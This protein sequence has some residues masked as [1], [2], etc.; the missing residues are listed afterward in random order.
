MAAW[1]KTG[2]AWPRYGFIQTQTLDIRFE[3]LR[4]EICDLGSGKCAL[5][6]TKSHQWKARSQKQSCFL[7]F[8]E[9]WGDKGGGVN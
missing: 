3:D 9:E 2:D 4:R 1:A 7:F 8:S 5:E 6:K